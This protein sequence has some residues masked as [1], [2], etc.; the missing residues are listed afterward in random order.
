LTANDEMSQLASLVGVYGL[1]FVAALIAVTP[2]LIWPADGRSL[3]RRLVPFFLSIVVIAAQVGYGNYRLSTTIVEPRDDMRMRLVQ[4]LVREHTDWAVADPATIMDQLIG[5]S[6]TRTGPEDPGLEGVTQLVWPESVFPFF[7]S[8]YPPALARIA[9]MLPE[10]TML[11]TGAPREGWD[12]DQGAA[13]Q[14]AAAYNA[15]LAIDS[16]GEIVGSYDKSHL[17]PFGEYLPFADF[18]ARF[19]IRQFVPGTNGWAAGTGRRLVDTGG[20][21]PFI[22]MIC[23]EAIFPGDLGADPAAAE[24]ILNVTN[25]AWFDGSIGPAQHAH[26]AR[27]RAVESGLPLVRAANSGVTMLVDPLGRVTARLA[28]R[29]MAVLDVV[30]TEKLPD[31]V[32]NRVGHWPFFLAI[33]LALLAAAFA[34]RRRRRPAGA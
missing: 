12:L 32:F 27:L 15:I 19:G 33:G 21:P 28:E 5:L 3:T 26:H 29:E 17:V 25:D 13:A 20:T 4:P 6:Q 7:L 31:T 16:D 23:Y 8:A 18:F 22:A 11:L 24:F 30:P 2:A 9:R 1:T 10:G 14:G 34:A